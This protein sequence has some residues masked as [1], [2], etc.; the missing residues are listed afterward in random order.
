MKKAFPSVRREL[1]LRKFSEGGGS[2]SLIR[3]IWAIYRGAKGTVRGM[4]G[5]GELFDFLLGTREGGG[6]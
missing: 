3:I 1:L 4:K 5:Y 2:D 6:G